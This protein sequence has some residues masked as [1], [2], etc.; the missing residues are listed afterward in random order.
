MANKQKIFFRADAGPE[1]GYGHFIRSLALV[2]MLK[3]EFDCTM[4]TQ[5][6]TEYQINE[7]KDICQIVALPS[8]NNKFGKF[9]EYLHGDEI[10]VL[11]NYFY[12]TDYQRAIKSKGC[13]LV[14]ID[15]MHD[16]HF[17]ADYIINSAP[18][19]D[20]SCYDVVPQTELHLGLNYIMMRK[21]FRQDTHRTYNS[22]LRKSIFV[23]FGG[24]DEHDLTYS[25]CK[26]LLQKIDFPIQAVVGGHYKGLER[27]QS[28]DASR[29][30]IH[31]NLSAEQMVELMS[32]AVFAVVPLST[33]FY[34]ICCTRTPVITGYDAD[35]QLG[36]AHSAK[37]NMMSCNLGN[38]LENFERKLTQVIA[39]L[40]EERRQQM[41]QKQ[42]EYVTDTE[43]N[44]VGLF[45]HISMTE[46][47]YFGAVSQE[48]AKADL[49]ELLDL[50]ENPFHPLAFISAPECV[51]MG[52]N[53]SMSFLTEIHARGSKV[54]IKDNCD[55]AAFVSINV[56]DSHKRCIGLMDS[57]EKGPIT[58]EENVF[59]GSH[60]F[61]GK[62]T[63]I[64]HHSVVAAGTIIVDGGEIPPYSLIKGNPAIVYPGYYKKYID[65]GNNV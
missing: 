5:S 52:K 32:E 38:L 39:Y 51:E 56:A 63:H 4:F 27:L 34:E 37:N 35:N 17:V 44:F 57:I 60:C 54:V 48:E 8:D 53:V 62:N 10:V 2:D 50:R 41:V 28:L 47:K 23:C 1:I 59:V 22:R 30:T 49:I 33:T 42:M 3:Q 12:D 36:M 58:L 21:P 6:P 43:E 18:D 7:A 55:I 40:T 11:D 19:L 24:S 13:K 15:D 46:R 25:A 31:Q 20:A 61:I 14:C 9:L 16:K 45:K 64:G 29:V 65:N 26:V